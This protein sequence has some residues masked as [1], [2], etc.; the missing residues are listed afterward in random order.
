MN[1]T[2]GEEAVLAELRKVLADRSNPAHSIFMELLF[3]VKDNDTLAKMFDTGPDAVFAEAPTDAAA[4]TIHP[5]NGTE[6]AVEAFSKR[7]TGSEGVRKQIEG[8][9]RSVDALL[10]SLPNLYD[11]MSKEIQNLQRE[12]DSL[13]GQARFWRSCCETI[14]KEVDELKVAVG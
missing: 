9:K 1:K 12:R 4:E 2:T 11:S 3:G 8:I 5:N 6:A 10:L 14:R 7:L 13:A